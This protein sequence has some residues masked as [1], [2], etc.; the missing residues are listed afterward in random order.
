[1]NTFL[2][3]LTPEEK[4]KS[5]PRLLNSIDVLIETCKETLEIV[6]KERN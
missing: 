5:L 2:T 1:M 6:K 4:R 3:E